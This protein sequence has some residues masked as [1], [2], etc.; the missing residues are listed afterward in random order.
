MTAWRESMIQI[1]K[2]E[3]IIKMSLSELNGCQDVI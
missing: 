1:G 2:L 3:E